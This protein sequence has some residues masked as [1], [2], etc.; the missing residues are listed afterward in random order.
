MFNRSYERDELHKIAERL[1]DIEDNLLSI[2]LEDER[3]FSLISSML[4]N[5]SI[6]IETVSFNLPDSK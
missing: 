3:L 6:L 1:L 2:H 4:K 5:A